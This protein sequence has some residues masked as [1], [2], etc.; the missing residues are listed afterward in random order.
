MRILLILSIAVL[1]FSCGETE[2]FLNNLNQS[3]QIN[4]MGE[5]SAPV[6]KDSIKLSQVKYHISLRVTDANNN[7]KEVKYSQLEGTGKLLQDG[8]EIQSNNIKFERDSSIL[9]FDYYPATLGLHRFSITV[10]DNFGL[11]KT[12]IVE[13]TA[14]E[15]LLPV[16]RFTARKIGQLSRYEWKFDASESYDRDARYGGVIKEYE[17]SVLGKVYT[18]LS[19]HVFI[20][21][22]QTGIYTVSVRV[23]DNDGKWS[24]KSEIPNLQVD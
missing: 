2:D 8:V 15:N 5:T 22:P 21:F 3:P 4:F 9:Q 16:S 11:A 24:T 23:K 17:F 12:A 14:F 6:L 20:I 7:I 10:T 18:I 13:L 19:D 1:L